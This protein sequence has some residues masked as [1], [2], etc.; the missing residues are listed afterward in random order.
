MPGDG[1]CM[2]HSLAFGLSHAYGKPVSASDLIESVCAYYDFF[3]SFA[4]YASEPETIAQWIQMETGL[5][6]VEYTHQLKRNRKWGGYIDLI[7]VS[8][9][10]SCDIEVYTNLSSRAQYSV[11]SEC[12]T[13]HTKQIAIF[14][15]GSNHYDA[16][17][18]P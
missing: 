8:R 7:A 14:Y 17:Q 10:Y 4:L 6:I 9:I 2:F 3:A 1:R 12:P 16:I 11:A 13:S 18:L 5:S 15:N